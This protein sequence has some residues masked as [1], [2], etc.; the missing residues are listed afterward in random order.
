M[1]LVDG[2]FLPEIAKTPRTLNPELEVAMLGLK[3]VFVYFKEISFCRL[4]LVLN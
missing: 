2:W 1:F 4:R 3:T